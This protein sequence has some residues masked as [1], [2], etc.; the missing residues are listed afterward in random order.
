[1][2]DYSAAELLEIMKLRGESVKPKILRLCG[3]EITTSEA[4]ERLQCSVNTVRR[5]IT[6]GLLVGHTA[7]ENRRHIRL[8][9]WQFRRGSGVHP[10]VADLIQNFG[11][12]GWGLLHFICAPQESLSGKNHLWMIK[13]GRLADVIAA[14]RRMNPEKN[15]VEHVSQ[16]R[17]HRQI[18]RLPALRVIAMKLEGA[19][20]AKRVRSLK[21]QFFDGYYGKTAQP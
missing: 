5:L 11:S 19:T 14:A 17:V 20:G 10:W 2:K 21:K 9:K 1:M 13:R 12:N 3:D 15:T 16:V 6:K 18:A 7:L 8:P 4:A